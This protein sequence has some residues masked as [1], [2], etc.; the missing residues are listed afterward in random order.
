MGGKS[1]T[2]ER[3]LSELNTGGEMVKNDGKV[4]D[5]PNVCGS[6]WVVGVWVTCVAV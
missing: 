3:K 4:V 1:E 6:V 5:F 2:L